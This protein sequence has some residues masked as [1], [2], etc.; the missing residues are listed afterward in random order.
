M[1][2]TSDP[3]QRLDTAALSAEDEDDAAQERDERPAAFV[4]RQPQRTDVRRRLMALRR[5]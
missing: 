2:A 5:W 4:P 1:N 3:D